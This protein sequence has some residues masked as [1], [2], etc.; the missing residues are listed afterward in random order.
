VQ[1]VN[2]AFTKCYSLINTSTAP[3]CG[4]ELLHS[5]LLG[6][7]QQVWLCVCVCLRPLTRCRCCC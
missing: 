3:G 6:M 5:Y 1:A 2:I 7:L 4:P